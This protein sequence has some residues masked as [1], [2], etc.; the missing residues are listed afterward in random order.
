MSPVLH[1]SANRSMPMGPGS[2]SSSC[3]WCCW[4][5]SLRSC[6]SPVVWLVAAALWGAAGWAS[7]PTLQPALIGDRP[8]QAMPIIAFQM[9]A[10]Y[11][12]SAVGA[13]V[14]SSLLAAGA[15]AMGLVVWAVIPA[16]L[17]IVL[18]GW[19][20]VRALQLRRCRVVAVA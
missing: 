18:A 4:S 15:G 14:G 17:T 5:P 20:S 12:D 9:A 16:G 3:Q 19:I 13:A 7:V 10:M 2:C 6:A 11:L 8:E 1:W